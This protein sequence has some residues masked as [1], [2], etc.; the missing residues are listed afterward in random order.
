MRF[1]LRIHWQAALWIRIHIVLNYGSGS[2]FYG[3][4]DQDICHGIGALVWITILV[5]TGPIISG[6]RSVQSSGSLFPVNRRAGSRSI[7]K[8]QLDPNAEFLQ[9]IYIYV[10]YIKILRFTF[11]R[12]FLKYLFMGLILYDNSEIDAHEWNN[13]CFLFN[14]IFYGEGEGEL[15]LSSFLRNYFHSQ[16]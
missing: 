13:R 14:L 3:L 11:V 15:I 10:W 6:S 4:L 2:I 16:N 9:N 12:S 1:M 7:S 8:S 5:R